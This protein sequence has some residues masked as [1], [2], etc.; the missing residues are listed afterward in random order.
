MTFVPG[1]TIRCQVV[2]IINDIIPENNEEFTIE[3]TVPGGPPIRTTVTIID[4]DG[5]ILPL[6]LAKSEK[7][8]TGSGVILLQVI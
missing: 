7:V 3:L 1:T 2:P 8:V 4:E 5:T 6:I